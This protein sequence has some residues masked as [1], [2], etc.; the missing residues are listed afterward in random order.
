M[1][2]MQ[3]KIVC[4]Y[5]V[6]KGIRKNCF[7]REKISQWSLSLSHTFPS[8]RYC[9][10]REEHLIPLLVVAAAAAQEPGHVEYRDNVLGVESV[11]FV[12]GADKI[13]A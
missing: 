4:V 12:F 8:A 7:H 11:D 9:H 1:P 5:T 10:P 6:L 3:S 2:L 13:C